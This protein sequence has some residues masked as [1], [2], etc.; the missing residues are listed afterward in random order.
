MKGRDKYKQ[1][2]HK[3][4][5]FAYI[6]KTQEQFKQTKL[7]GNIQVQGQECTQHSVLWW[8]T[9]MPKV[10]MPMSKSKDDLARLNFLV[11]I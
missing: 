6:Q 3:Q 8:Y 4:N 1:V 10:G 2:Y 5:I 7:K 11:K 9:H